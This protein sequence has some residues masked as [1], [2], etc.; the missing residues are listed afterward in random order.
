M[1][2]ELRYRL[3][4]GFGLAG[5]VIACVILDMARSSHQA[6]LGLGVAGALAGG[7][8]FTRLARHVL[9][10]D[11]RF[12]PIAVVTVLLVLE[13]YLHPQDTYIQAFGTQPVVPLILGLGMAWVI[14]A[15]MFRHGSE[16][17][18]T[19]VGLSLLGMLYLGIALNLLER[20]ALLNDAGRNLN[21][22]TQL[23]L[24]FL[25]CLKLGD[26][27]AFF[28]GRAFGRHRMAPRISP[29]KTWEG[30]AAS[31]VGAQAGAFACAGLFDHFCTSQPFNAWWKYAVW[32]FILGPLG[33]AGDLAESCMK[34]DAAVKDSG[35]ALPGFGGFL[36]VLD[37]LILASPVAYA[38]AL[39]L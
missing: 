10:A 7:Y 38:L 39:A 26:V 31:F 16:R 17:F 12:I 5:V 34:R 25:A 11:V 1:R 35:S 8:E 6:L 30:F 21:R 22:G 27:A 29:G 24:L 14:L 28:G 13:A 18:L 2:Q 9:S 19:N 3:I 20:L 37:A 36:D 15:Q 4:L 23:V 32:A 33:V